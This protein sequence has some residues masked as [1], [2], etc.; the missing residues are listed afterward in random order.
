MFIVKQNKLQRGEKLG[1]GGFGSV[2]PY[3]KDTN[4][5]RWVVKIVHTGN[6]L[7]LF[8][9]TLQE[10]VLGFSCEHPALIRLRAFDIKD[11]PKEGYVI[12]IKMERME[13]NLWDFIRAHKKS[14]QGPIPKE[15]IIQYFYTLVCGL[16]YLRSKCIRYQARKYLSR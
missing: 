7:R 1:Q 13:M 5:S 2:F 12:Y 16:E 10:I 15:K 9:L 14:D 6:N 8:K 3:Q 4:E 11:D